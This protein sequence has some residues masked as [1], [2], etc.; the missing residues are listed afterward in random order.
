MANFYYVSETNI[1]DFNNYIQTKTKNSFGIYF[2]IVKDYK[3]TEPTKNNQKIKGI[4]PR[5]GP[6][7]FAHSVK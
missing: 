7:S 2:I 3:R 5:F 6:N 4:F 1:I